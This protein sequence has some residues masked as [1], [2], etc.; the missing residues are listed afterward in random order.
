VGQ[1]IKL[2]CG[3][4]SSVRGLVGCGSAFG[5]GLDEK[6]KVLYFFPK[7]FSSAKQIQE[8]PRKCLKARKILRKS[9]KSQENS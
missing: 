2:G 6:D 3:E 8:K 4:R 1:D 9:Q 5:L 7:L